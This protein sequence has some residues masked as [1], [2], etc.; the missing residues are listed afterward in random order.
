MDAQQRANNDIVAAC[1]AEIALLRKEMQWISDTTTD[2]EIKLKVY[3][4]LR[5]SLEMPP[6]END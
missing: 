6:Q 5:R 3:Y 4:V 2:P 1:L